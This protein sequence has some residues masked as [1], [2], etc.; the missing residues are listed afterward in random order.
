MNTGD[1]A[2]TG[3]DACDDC[4]L[5]SG[6]GCCGGSDHGHGSLRSDRAVAAAAG[7]ATMLLAVAVL[8]VDAARAAWVVG[9]A[10]LTALGGAV[11][12][13]LGLVALGR[14]GVAGETAIRRALR[15]LP[16]VSGGLVVSLG[17]ALVALIT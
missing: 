8:T 10:V 14:S 1:A 4:A 7:A 6:E 16:I 15:L 17:L 2:A 12:L 3:L 9:P 5:S 11:L 13:V